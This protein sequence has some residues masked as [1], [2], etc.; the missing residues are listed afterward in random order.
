MKL[1][2]DLIPETTFFVNVRSAVSQDEW[3]YLRSHCYKKARYQC[4]ICSGVGPSHPVEC[5]EVWQYHGGTQKLIRL[6]ALCPAC[7][8]VQHLGLAEINGRLEQAIQHLMSVNRWSAAQAK[9]HVD[10]A[11]KVWRTRSAQ[12]WTLDLTY[13]DNTLKM[14]RTM[15]RMRR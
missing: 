13:L 10:H 14:Y 5:H 15:K 8:E 9:S 7:H 3:D 4:E 2:A 12:E 1:S 6:I 11:F